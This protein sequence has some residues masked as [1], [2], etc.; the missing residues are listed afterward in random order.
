[1][2]AQLPQTESKTTRTL[3]FNEDNGE[4]DK[5]I[6]DLFQ[7]A[8]GI[9]HPE[10]I[11]ELILAS[12]KAGQENPEKADLKL[13]NS[14]LKEMRYTSKVFGAYRHVRKVT[15][16]GSARS[17]ESE[18]IYQMAYDFG[19]K[20]A[21]K[22]YMAI[23]GGGSG[24]MQAVNEGAGV[25]HSFGIN[26]R[27]PYEQKSNHVME[28]SPRNIVYKYFFNRKIAFIKETN[29]VV[30]FPGGFGTLDEAMEVLTLLQTGKR[31]PMPLILIECP[32]GDYWPS[33]IRLLR[34]VLLPRGNIDSNDFS[35]FDL[36]GSIDE[37]IEKIGQFYRRYHSIRYIQEKM[38]I[39]LLS[40]IDE[41]AVRRLKNHF[42]DILV[43]GG[44]LYLSKALQ[45][46]QDEP[47]LNS[48]TRLVM[49]FNKKDFGRLRQMI[50]AINVA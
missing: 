14:T 30:L 35:L 12:L 37:A 8:G 44:D 31:Y 1:M 21:E 5:T 38:V 6:Y 25:D 29:A 4:I 2:N 46:E 33:W 34:D 17:S 42:S 22:G 15:V 7:L 3:H 23:T 16:F 39:R 9:H 10:I 32:E 20:L 18:P 48:L 45:E 26:I 43:T 47:E 28:G 13:M 36:V 11:R 40:T 27:L 49:D 19:V 50:D 41:S 24:I